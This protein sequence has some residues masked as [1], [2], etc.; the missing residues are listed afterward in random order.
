[1]QTTLFGSRIHEKKKMSSK[2]H[3]HY[4]SHTSI[5]RALNGFFDIQDAY[6]AP[7]IINKWSRSLHL[8]ILVCEP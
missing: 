3:I 6:T 1:V 7:Q 8:S 5:E 2:I 4:G